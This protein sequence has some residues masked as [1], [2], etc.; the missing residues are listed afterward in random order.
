MIHDIVTNK[1]DLDRCEEMQTNV[2]IGLKLC[3]DVKKKLGCW[4]FGMSIGK[5]LILHYVI[6]PTGWGAFQTTLEEFFQ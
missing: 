6:N 1:G 5:H 3:I 4:V 2:Y